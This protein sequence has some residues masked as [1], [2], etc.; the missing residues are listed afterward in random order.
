VRLEEYWEAVN[1]EVV[2]QEGGATE[3]ETRLTG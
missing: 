3:A 1:L 2:V